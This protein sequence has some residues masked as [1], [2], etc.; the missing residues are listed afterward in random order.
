MI[1]LLI[2]I[3]CV[4]LD[5]FVLMMEKG[6][7]NTSINFKRA[8]G[9]GLIFAACSTILFFLGNYLANYIFDNTMI[10]INK[11]IAV[12]VFFYISIKL[13][14][15]AAKQ[16]NYIERLTNDLTYHESLKN[17]II[18]GIDCFLIGISTSYMN[19]PIISQC[20]LIF[21]VTL[22]TVYIALIVGYKYGAYYQKAI[23]YI[24]GIIYSLFSLIQT[25]ILFIR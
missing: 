17:A 5:V 7:T 18:T 4:S 6:A 20:L 14:L 8:I 2:F 10:R 24:S 16:H 12:V 13:F 3:I 19:I 11:F 23:C 25:Y 1:W 15:A 21:V 9:H 22:L